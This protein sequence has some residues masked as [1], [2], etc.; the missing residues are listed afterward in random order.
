MKK[1]RD[2][3]I[4]CK[5][6]S[7]SLKLCLVILKMQSLSFVALETS[8]CL[9][10]TKQA[11]TKATRYSVKAFLT[12][13][14]TTL[15][16]FVREN[17][18]FG[19]FHTKFWLDTKNSSAKIVVTV[20]FILRYFDQMSENEHYAPTTSKSVSSWWF[21]LEPILIRIAELYSIYICGFGFGC[22]SLSTTLIYVS[23]FHQCF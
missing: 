19:L 11:H 7:I 9:N 4:S 17:L 8:S 3:G 10:L 13:K 21:L 12:I 5:N 14:A 15:I 22:G 16:I 18:A 20:V 23:T 1:K 2:H 6:K